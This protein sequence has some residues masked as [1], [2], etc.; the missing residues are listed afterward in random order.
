MKET[1]DRIQSGQFAKEWIAETEAGYPNFN[2][3]REEEKHHQIEEVGK[4]VR[5]LFSWSKAKEQ[6][7]I[8]N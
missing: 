8:E 4:E 5:S 3:V 6:V 2:K 7:K 1:L